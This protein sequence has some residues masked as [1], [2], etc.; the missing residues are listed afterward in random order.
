MYTIYIYIYTH[1]D[2][3]STMSTHPV[4][5]PDWVAGPPPLTIMIII[6]IIIASI[7]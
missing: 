5:L 4:G 6:C 7:V 2:I 3:M 1:I